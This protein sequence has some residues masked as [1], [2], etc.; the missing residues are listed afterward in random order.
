L[1]RY[2]AIAGGEQEVLDYVAMDRMGPKEAAADY[3][4]QERAREVSMRAFRAG[5]VA[6]NDAGPNVEPALIRAGALGWT[7]PAATTLNAPIAD[8]RGDLNQ[9][10]RDTPQTHDDV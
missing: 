7:D 1:E 3:A 9:P 5:G 8:Y 6:A 2:A 4:R 10:L